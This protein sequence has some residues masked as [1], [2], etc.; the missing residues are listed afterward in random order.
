[1]SISANILMLKEHGSLSVIKSDFITQILRESFTAKLSSVWVSRFA[2]GLTRRTQRHSQYLLQFHQVYI[3]TVQGIVLYTKRWQGKG[4][5]EIQVGERHLLLFWLSLQTLT[6]KGNPLGECRVGSRG[7]M[8]RR[9]HTLEVLHR[10]AK[11]NLLR[12]LTR[13]THNDPAM[14]RSHSL[15]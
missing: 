1:M 10:E 9:K 4:S 14:R 11:E 7:S 15:A 12:A 8:Y 13:V 5:G 3:Q 6:Q 2:W